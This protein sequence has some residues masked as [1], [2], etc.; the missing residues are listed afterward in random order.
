M[1]SWSTYG[2]D[3]NINDILVNMWARLKHKWHLGQHVGKTET[4]CKARNIRENLIIANIGKLVASQIQSSRLL[5]VTIKFIEYN[6]TNT[7]IPDFT[8]NSEIENS[9]NKSQVKI[10]KFTVNDILVNM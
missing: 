7:R 5:R 8:N 6:D 2:Q 10:S 9:R 4:Y 3:C 1:T